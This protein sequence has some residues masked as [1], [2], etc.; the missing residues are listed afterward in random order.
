[1]GEKSGQD[2]RPAHDSPFET[3][4]EVQ[5]RLKIRLKAT[6]FLERVS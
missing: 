1:M 6:V 2:P 4:F 5:R 3:L